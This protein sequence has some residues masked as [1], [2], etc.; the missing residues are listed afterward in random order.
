M[1]RVKSLGYGAYQIELVPIS[2]VYNATGYLIIGE[3][4]TVLIETGASR[5]NAAI[6]DALSQLEVSTGSIDAIIA[7]HIHL[8]HSGGAG[9][10][11]E[12]CPN[13]VMMVHEKGVPHLVDPERLITG[14]RVVYGDTFDKYFDPVK[15]IAE[16]RVKPLLDGD[17]LDLGG[18]R[19][20][21]FLSSPGH[22]L[23]HMMVFDEVSEGIFTGDAA[24]IYYHSLE[25]EFGAK[26]ALPSTT[27]TQFDPEAM[28]T[29]L[30]HMLDLKPQRLYYTHYGMAE[31]A[32]ELLKSTKAWLS[33][34]AEAC[35]AFYREHRSLEKLSHYLQEEVMKRLS[36][37]GVTK[38]ARCLG[39]MT[40]DNQINA[41]GL[42][43]YVERLERQKKKQELKNV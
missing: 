23:H 3:E 32:G 5:S 26:V 38:K 14:S 36:A 12:Q 2:E 4:K 16:K 17:Q 43:A 25:Q 42:I 8:D 29:T 1:G 21:A 30:N 20:L 33:L 7:T 28:L 10:L 18:G 19:Q 35:V 22:A 31:P 24:G 40:I 34:F 39:Y 27:P 11:M 9:V 15:A 6:L 37:E 13:A 41:Q